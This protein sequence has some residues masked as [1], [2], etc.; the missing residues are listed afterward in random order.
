MKHNSLFLKNTDNLLYKFCVF[1]TQVILT[2]NTCCFGAVRNILAF[3]KLR[4]SRQMM[5]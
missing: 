4:K 3:M 5:K 2:S 1:E